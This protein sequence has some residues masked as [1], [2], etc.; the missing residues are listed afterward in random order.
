MVR[1]RP[2]G[3]S[4]TSKALVETDASGQPECVRYSS[5][6][7]EDAGAPIVF[8]THHLP[9]RTRAHL[10]C[11][12]L[13][14]CPRGRGRTYCVRYSSPAREDAGAPIVFD[15]HHLPA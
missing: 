2:R 1:P 7:R 3:L 10:L 15:T 11:S 4:L 13:I 14:T 5:P 8:D 6:A 12:I 9:A